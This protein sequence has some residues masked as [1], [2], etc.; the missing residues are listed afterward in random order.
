MSK[1]DRAARAKDAAEGSAADSAAAE[2][3]G[4]DEAIDAGTDDDTSTGTAKELRPSG[5][6]SARG[7]R[8]AAGA[9][10][11]DADSDTGSVAVKERKTKKKASAEESRNPFVR[12]WVFLT[13]VVAE[14]K[15]VIWPNRREMITYTIVVLVFVIVMTAFIAGLDLAF[16]KGVLWLFG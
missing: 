5:K 13:Q 10:D 4:R 7:R 3:D 2:L 16:A 1:R 6:R 11:G 9:T 8:S 12:I 15:K 14:L